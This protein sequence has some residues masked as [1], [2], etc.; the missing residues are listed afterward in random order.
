[1]SPW[2][3]TRTASG[4]VK[5]IRAITFDCA[6]TL[7]D[8]RWRP[9][10]LA[11]E[12]A[13]ALGLEFDGPSAA[14]EY[15]SLLSRRWSEFRA[16]NQTRDAAVCDAFW[17]RLTADWVAACG[18]PQDRVDD[19]I[20]EAQRRLFGPKQEIFNLYDDVPETLA[21]LRERGYRLAIVSNW[22]ISLHRVVAMHGLTSY[23]ETVIASLEEGVEKPDPLIFEIAL[24][25]LEVRASET[26]HVGDNAMD[27]LHGAR[28]AGMRGLLID[29]A[30]PKSGELVMNRLTDLLDRLP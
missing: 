7:V 17:H 1:M 10:I 2:R 14:E 8:V 6:Q 30:Q 27:D 18:L 19:L 4:P 11:V 16:L 29:R 9:A 3:P 20:G 23:F 26:L 25:R 13:R 21:T 22:D 24:R 12:S 5:S 28:S 15:N